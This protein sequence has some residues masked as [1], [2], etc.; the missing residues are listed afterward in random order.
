MYGLRPEYPTANLDI[1]GTPKMAFVEV[2]TVQPTLRWEPFP[3]ADARKA[4]R[5]G[6]LNRIRDVSYDLRIFGA[7]HDHPTEVLYARSELSEPSHKVETALM[8]AAKYFWTVR[9]RFMLDGVTRVTP[10]ARILGSGSSDFVAPSRYYFGL[11]T[12]AR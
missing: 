6:R 10:W 9:A 12:P 1:T 3:D 4:D 2:D 7:E 5:D 8:P 11:K